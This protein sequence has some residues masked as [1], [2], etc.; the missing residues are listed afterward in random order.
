MTR[1]IDPVVGI[2]V[3]RLIREA[4]PGSHFAVE[5]LPGIALEPGFLERNAIPDDARRGPVEEIFDGPR[6]QAAGAARGDLAA[7]VLGP[8]GG[9]RR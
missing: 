5:R 3:C 7:G 4:V 9:G 2:E 6:A 8:R 1:T